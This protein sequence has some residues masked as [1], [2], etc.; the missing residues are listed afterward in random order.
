MIRLL[1]VL[2]LIVFFS[3]VAD[4]QT[5]I[6]GTAS[7]SVFSTDFARL[8]ICL[9]QTLNNS[10][11]LRISP[12]MTFRGAPIE[13]EMGE[14][15]SAQ[16]AYW[17]VPVQLK[18]QLGKEN[19]QL[20]GLVGVELGIGHRIYYRYTQE[21]KNY[22][23]TTTF[24]HLGLRYADIGIQPGLGFQYTISKGK[25]VMVDYQYYLGLRDL[26]P[27][28]SGT[29]YNEGHGVTVGLMIPLD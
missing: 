27:T 5:A 24:S 14:V 15:I 12:G 16:A 18:A 23:A 19:L 10:L 1:Y 2:P 9:E 20:Y 25:R 8:N 28:E 29:L 17:S 7:S 13:L 3:I 4:A 22:K 26:D 21:N 11:V 6:G